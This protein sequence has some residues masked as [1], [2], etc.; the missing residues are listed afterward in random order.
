MEFS[1]NIQKTPKTPPF[2]ILERFFKVKC[3][4]MDMYFNC[5]FLLDYYCN[6][7]DQ[8]LE[9]RPLCI[10]EPKG[11]TCMNGQLEKLSPSK[12]LKIKLLTLSKTCSFQNHH[13]VSKCFIISLNQKITLQNMDKASN[14]KCR[15]IKSSKS[16][17]TYQRKAI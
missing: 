4:A 9:Y 17:L 2:V 11:S 1:Q 7:G 3:S 5:F 15:K 13:E 16:K 12:P 14:C 8:A 6:L 10:F